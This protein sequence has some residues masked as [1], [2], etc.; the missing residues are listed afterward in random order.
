MLQRICFSLL[1][2]YLG[3]TAQSRSLSITPEH[4]PAYRMYDDG[5]P[6]QHAM[7]DPCLLPADTAGFRGAVPLQKGT[8]RTKGTLQINASEIT[9][10]KVLET[11]KQAT[12]FMVEKAGYKGAYV[13]AYLPDLSRRWGELEAYPTMGWVQA[14]GTGSMGHLLLDAYHATG[15]EYYYKAACEA[16]HALIFAQLSCGGWNYMFDY[17]GESSVKQWYATI[18]K[19][20]WR[21]EEFQHYYGN[22]TFDDGGTI[23][24]GELLLRMFAEKKDSTFLPPLEKTIRFV[25]ESQYPSGG[26]PQR[27]P[28]TDDHSFFGKADYSSFITLNDDVSLENIEFLLQCR[29]VMDPDIIKEPVTRAMDVLIRLQNKAPFAGWADQY[30]V[31]DLKPAPARSYEARAINAGTTVKM[32]HL[33]MKYY[34]LTGEAKFL[35]GIPAAIDFLESIKLPDAEVKRSGKTLRNSSE[36]L[37]PRYIDPETGIPQYIHRKGSNG[38][39]YFDQDI[40]NTV[41]HIGSTTVIHI[42]GLRKAYEEITSIPKDELTQ[43]SPL[44]YGKKIP[45]PEYYSRAPFTQ[46]NRDVPEIINSLEKEGYWLTPLSMISNPYK[47]CPPMPKSENKKHASTHVGDEYDTSTYPPETPVWGIS[48]PVYLSNM[49]KLITYLNN[50]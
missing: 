23:C 29:H 41:S 15:D 40:A 7:D 50:K 32:I 26:W 22:A 21:M 37:V 28:L 4:T 20:A 13:W 35:S 45:L 6:L 42:S 14:P 39:Y 25:L 11:M 24:S 19:Q 16:A 30:F 12:R 10:E 36:I 38:Y 27:Y 44:I 8:P 18:G 34:R 46:R 31:D 1:F 49:V 5:D 9:R 48:M 17:N 47:E 33:L 3:L 43:D 2:L